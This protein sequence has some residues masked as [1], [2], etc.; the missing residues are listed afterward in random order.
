MDFKKASVGIRALI[1]LLKCSRDGS[2]E[3]VAA[4]LR[5]WGRELVADAEG[6][7]RGRRG[8]RGGGGRRR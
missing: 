1:C 6:G 5:R 2:G 7:G 4:S 8:G 3:R